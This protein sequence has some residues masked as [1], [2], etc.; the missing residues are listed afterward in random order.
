M[1]IE[2]DEQANYPGSKVFASLANAAGLSV[3][4]VSVWV[5]K[6][7]KSRRNDKWVPCHLR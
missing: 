4:L 7:V 2:L 1:E 3:D 5:G 6:M